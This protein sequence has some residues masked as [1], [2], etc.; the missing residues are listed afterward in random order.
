MNTPRKL[1]V[2]VPA[3]LAA[4]IALGL[5]A[6]ARAQQMVSGRV[7]DR[8]TG[9]PL[10][11]VSIEIT[12]GA[13]AAP[14][15]VTSD[16][17]G[18][19]LAPNLAPGAYHVRVD[20]S[21][22]LEEEFD[23]ELLP[24]QS[25]SMDIRLRPATAANQAVV[26]R[27]PRLVDTTNYTSNVAVPRGYVDEM[28]MTQANSMADVVSSLYSGAVVGH[29]NFV[30]L[31][32]NELS[33]NYFINGVSF[34][35]NTYK[36]FSPALSP[37]VFE[38]INE[39]NG[40]FSAE[41]GN[42]FGGILDMTTKSGLSQSGHG[43]AS[44]GG[45]TL[46]RGDAAAEYG[47]RAGSWGFYGNAS[48]LT[49]GRFLNP[50]EPA[51]TDNTG[52]G[53]RGLAQADYASGA[54]SIKLLV[55]GGGTDFRLPTTTEQQE[56]GRNASKDVR[57]QTFI[58]TWN[59][60]LG[61]T[62]LLSASGY[63]RYVRESV[64]P[65]TDPITTL[66]DG[67]R[68][69]ITAGAKLDVMMDAGAGNIVKLGVDVKALDL[70]ESL[71]IDLRA[72]DDEEPEVGLRASAAGSH[73]PRFFPEHSGGPEELEVFSF[74]DTHGGTLL[75]MYAQDEFQPFDA[76]TVD[77]G[78]RLDRFDVLDSSTELSPRVNLAYGIGNG[79]VVH[80]AYNRFF[81][82][83]AI[84]WLLLGSEGIDEALPVQP[85]ISDH[86]ETG[87][88]AE[89]GSFA[90]VTANVFHRDDDNPFET[91]EIFDTN[92]FTPTN[93]AAGEA[94]GLELALRVQEIESVG[95]SG[96]LSYSLS[97]TDF[98][99]PLSGGLP[100][101]ELAPGERVPPAFDQRNS[102]VSNVVWRERRSG[103]WVGL[104]FQYGSGTPIEAATEGDDGQG[105]AHFLRLPSHFVVDLQV[106]VDLF[107]GA[108]RT[109]ALQFNALNLTD[110][111]IPIAKE[112]VLT[113]VQ[114]GAP[115]SFGFQ[116]RLDF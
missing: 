5:P 57:Q 90:S 110:E 3:L 17:A 111:L 38:S 116:A 96:F 6:A 58:G 101:E 24:R 48:F 86:F 108:D 80:A 26:V 99:G 93:F 31:R 73:S 92:V 32:G 25:R 10:A 60:T 97:K 81:A 68:V 103:A 66:A 91:A 100:G 35:D 95:L 21:G 115:R 54:D 2:L 8:A 11:G 45:G 56:D 51:T 84:E 19:F 59:R 34:L 63:E 98:I 89:L 69:T 20:L 16:A 70:N 67:R 13:L 30:H 7:V 37:R 44:V 94:R 85:M 72:P 12:G 36:Q 114:Y 88:R 71:A 42:R 47:D 113:P 76:F 22:Y 50:P 53:M 75:G 64:L 109:L 102:L 41:F 83:P 61:E 40:G 74:A 28:P 107:R 106:G 15:T 27:A 82:P 87:V 9:E 14:M 29:D 65:T 52:R 33:M 112:S 49:D 23:T 4:A 78:L 55:S 43:S 79:F 62:G 39:I 18:R 105:G 1:I 104:G 46:E 77:V